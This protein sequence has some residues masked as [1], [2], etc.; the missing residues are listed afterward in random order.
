MLAMMGAT[1]GAIAA[2]YSMVAKAASVEGTIAVAEAKPREDVFAYVSRT[3]GKFDQTLYQQVIGAANDFKEGDQAIGVGA[4]DETSRKNART[5]LANTRIRDFDA[6]PLFVDDLQKLIWQTTDKGQYAKV[7]D[8]TMGQLKE[9][10]LTRSEAEIKGVMNGLTS[11]VIGCV[12]KM[13]SNEELTVVGQ[14]IFNVLPGTQMGAKG[15][16]GARIQPN[17]PTDHPEDVIW[18]VFDAFAYA[19][20]DIVIG[21][22]PVDSTVKSV[23]AVEQALKDVVDTFGLKDTIP[24]CVLAHIDVQAAVAESYPGTVAT[25]FQSLAG[26]DDCNKTF[27][28]T[29]EK[30]LNY[31]KAKT[32]QRYG[33]YFE[34]GQGSE[35]T[36]GAANG[37]DMMILESRKYGFSRAV[38]QELAKVQ[39]SGAWLHINDVAGFIGPEV[40]RSREQLVRC[41]L[42]DI[43]M[44]KL[45]GLTIG[46]D[47]CSTLHMAV[48]LED[49]DWCQD[50]IMPASPVYL[51]ALP[52][53]NDPMLGYLTTSFQDHVRLRK[54]FGFKVNDAMWDFYKRI[55][56][57]DDANNYTTYY[58]DPLWVYY[59]YRLAKGDTRPK[60]A[61]YAEGR[62]MMTE[63]E[64]R[65]VD[66][67]TGHGAQIWDLNP[68]LDARVN[69]LYDD[70]KKSLWTELT[71]GFIRA[72]PNVLPI[73][74]QSKDRNDY[75]A[76]PPTGE[77]LD[78]ESLAAI[79]RLRDS[80]GGNVPKAQIVISDGLNAN[81]I[82]DKGHLEP[83]LGEMRR[84][85]RAAGV[86]VA[87]KN[88]LVTSGRVRVGYRIG[89][90][91]FER[92]DPNSFR[93]V[94]HII[95]E[96]PGTMHHAYSVYITVA[97]GNVWAQ[98]KIDHDITRLVSNVADTALPP[99]EAAKET[100]TIIRE[101]VG[102]NVSGSRRH[103]T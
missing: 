83:Y 51:I 79:V 56:I 9:F 24:W 39:P 78:P 33:L 55:K 101:V 6:Y 71:P 87:D 66:L 32:G 59:Q 40:F 23:V 30:I 54:K 21:T 77:I 58:G 98:K 19:T 18:Q 1:S 72:I 25:V 45:H 81:A 50:Q 80:W 73:R 43:V 93:G 31:A 97:Q 28:I 90:T 99:E 74:T 60:E 85:L 13:M 62:R 26:T 91:L 17:S 69:S 42:E 70:A 82:M 27:D 61:V 103:A 2:G 64:Q 15:Y 41:C 92:A 88:I 100:L 68:A 95:G 12:P 16:M 65:G 35:F 11:D 22:N 4:K 5:L 63:V 84:L 49:L 14:K 102:K 47:I 10:L 8:W 48:T 57:V 96:R 7:Q 38:G 46:L 3:K 89:E 20:G 53:K 67:A 52:T 76:H 86:S 44:A 29:I 37:I 75:I 94:L 36:N 34:T